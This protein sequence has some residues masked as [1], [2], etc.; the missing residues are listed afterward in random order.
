MIALRASL[1]GLAMVWAFAALAQAQGVRPAQEGPS[2]EESHRQFLLLRSQVCRSRCEATRRECSFRALERYCAGQ[3]LAL[4][5][6]GGMG[7]PS[8][9]AN[10]NLA[11]Y[12]W[13]AETA[14]HGIASCGSDAGQRISV[15]P[16]PEDEYSPARYQQ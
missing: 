4:C 12:K 11:S 5:E 14:K 6:N 15:C 13:D 16:G 1:W 10:P 8:I 3:S 2:A 7:A 9:A